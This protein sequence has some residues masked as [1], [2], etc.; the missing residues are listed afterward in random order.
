M[1]IKCRSH[2]NLFISNSGLSTLNSI[3]AI[4]FPNKLLPSGYFNLTVQG[5]VTLKDLPTRTLMAAEEHKI[6]VNQNGVVVTFVFAY[7][8]NAP[9]PHYEEGKDEFASST[10]ASMP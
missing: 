7:D 8:N 6:V 5:V 9:C 3:F 2:L 4:S 10:I 1:T